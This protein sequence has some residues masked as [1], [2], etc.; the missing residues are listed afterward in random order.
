MVGHWV[1]M[2]PGQFGEWAGVGIHDVSSVVGAASV[3]GGGALGLTGD[4]GEVVFGRL[5]IVPVGLVAA[6]LC[7]ERVCGGG[8]EHASICPSRGRGRGKLQVPWFIGGICAGGRV[9]RTFVPGV[10]AIVP[11]TGRVAG[12]AMGVTLVVFF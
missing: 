2:T 1:G 12:A 9:V 7:G 11:V 6:W 5:W 3:Y 4:S 8:G 10:V